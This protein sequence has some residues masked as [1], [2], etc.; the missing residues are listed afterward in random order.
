MVNLIKN[1]LKKINIYLQPSNPSLAIME[2][3]VLF[4]IKPSTINIRKAKYTIGKGICMDWDDKKHSGKGEKFFFEEFNTY[5]CKNCFEKFIEINQDLK[6]EESISKKSYINKGHKKIIM[7]FYKTR[8]VNPI[9]IFEE[10]ITK[11]GECI[12][13]IDKIYENLKDR[14]IKTTMKFGGTFIDVTAIHLTSGKSVKTTL[15]F[16]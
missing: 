14:T 8:K 4:G 7:E 15:T 16:D 1:N 11:I 9:F 5:L 10:G 3:A 12:L 2:G 6:Y 13:D